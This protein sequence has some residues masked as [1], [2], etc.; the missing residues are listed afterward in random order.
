MKLVFVRSRPLKIVYRHAP[1]HALAITGL[2]DADEA[3]ILRSEV[4]LRGPI[5]RQV[6]LDGAGRASR[7]TG[8]SIVHGVAES[9][10][11]RNGVHMRGDMPRR[12]DGVDA[13]LNQAR[14]AGHTKESRHGRNESGCR[15][16]GC[17]Y[18]VRDVHLGWRDTVCEGGK[19]SSSAVATRI[20]ASNETSGSFK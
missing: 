7:S 12:Y 18:G 10:A 2:R 15:K 1:L 5:R 19:L 6:L 17:E 4:Q 11:A 16:G 14:R 20:D 8:L 9:I 13:F 3:A